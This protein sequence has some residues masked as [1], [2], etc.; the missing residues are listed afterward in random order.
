VL[1]MLASPVKD[2]RTCAWL[3]SRRARKCAA[4][5]TRLARGGREDVSGRGGAQT[6]RRALAARRRTRGMDWFFRFWRIRLGYPGEAAQIPPLTN[7]IQG[8]GRSRMLYWNLR[9]T[10][11]PRTPQRLPLT[12]PSTC[13]DDGR[14]GTSP[15]AQAE[16]DQDYADSGGG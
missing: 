10:G 16:L 5:L 1:A 3:R 12:T 2:G 14:T 6:H 15:R 9:A 8:Y 11:R 7:P 4:L 13:R